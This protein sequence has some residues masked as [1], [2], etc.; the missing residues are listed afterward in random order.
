MQFKNEIR[1]KVTMALAIIAAFGLTSCGSYQYVGQDSDGIYSSN[2]DY[3]EQEQPRTVESKEDSN[4]FYENYFQERANALNIADEADE[5]EEVFTDVDS[6]QSNYDTNRV[7]SDGSAG[8]GQ[9]NETTTI[10]IYN[11]NIGYSNYWNR[12]YY[13]WN[14]WGYARPYRGWN[15]SIGYGYNYGLYSGYYSPYYSPYYNPYYNPYYHGGHYGGY[16]SAGYYASSPYYGNYYRNG[17]TRNATRRGDLRS[18]ST[19]INQNTALGRRVTTQSRTNSNTRVRTESTP[20]TRTSTPRTSTPRPRATTPAKT[21]TTTPNRVRT[22]T[23]PR[24]STPRATTPNRTYSNSS[25][26]TPSRSSSPSPSRST[27]GSRRRG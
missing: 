22:T 17:V 21:R 26:S 11:N 6:Y 14:H 4:S 16:Y 23:T 10:N 19:N 24:T 15:I 1:S 5:Q 7:A 9:E 27:G 8:W 13:G 3:V 25:M 2:E 18:R 12:P 20:R